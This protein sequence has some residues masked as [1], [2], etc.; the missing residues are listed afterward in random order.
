MSPEGTQK[1]TTLNVESQH[2][3]VA[4]T[5]Q[6]SLI[7][8]EE[9]GN[10]NLLA[11]EFL[12][13]QRQSVM[14]TTST[15][16]L[17]NRWTKEHDKC[18]DGLRK[19]LEMV[20]QKLNELNH[21]SSTLFSYGTNL[22]EPWR[23]NAQQMLEYLMNGASQLEGAVNMTISGYYSLEAM[24]SKANKD[25]LRL[26]E[27][28]KELKSNITTLMIEKV[29]R[30][31]NEK[32]IVDKILEVEAIAM[33]SEEN[34][35]LMQK[36]FFED[37]KREIAEVKD[38]KSTHLGQVNQLKNL[39]S[40]DVIVNKV[41]ERVNNDRNSFSSSQDM[42]NRKIT[43]TTTNSAIVDKNQM[44][45]EE[46]RVL[47]T[48]K[49]T[50]SRCKYGLNCQNTKCRRRHHVD[51]EKWNRYGESKEYIIFRRKS[52]CTKDQRREE[53]KNPKR[54]DRI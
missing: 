13:T 7:Q 35:R 46:Y 12:S 48:Q 17:I 24:I 42:V 52:P 2:Q 36:K 38:W 26:T 40:E 37:V 22:L 21:N 45:E 3:D 31:R 30:C 29:N 41:S 44:D 53:E 32:E 14:N 1:E 39:Y 10:S 49:Q 8:I 25:I 15:L 54:G 18:M 28:N 20:D 34:M 47:N 4:N 50:A 51:G 27:E 9:T 43:H 19:Y 23:L 33:R 5:Q 6:R 16:T 11:S